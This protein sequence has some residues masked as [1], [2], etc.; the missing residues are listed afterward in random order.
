MPIDRARR[1]E[2]FIHVPDLS[3]VPE[4]VPSNSTR[5]AYFNLG[6]ARSVLVIP[7]RKDGTVLGTI[8]TYRQEVQPFT[9]KQITLLENFAA[10]A[11]I[12]MENARLLTETQQALD[13]QT[14]TTEVLQVINASPGDLAPV[15][16]AILEKA[17]ALCEAP[18]GSLVLYGGEQL[19][20]IAT[21]GYPSE[22]DDL[23]RRGFPPPLPFRR[24][25]DGKP[26]FLS[27]PAD[28]EPD[29]DDA[30]DAMR[31]AAVEI[32]GIRTALFVP[33]R[34][35]N[36]VLGYISA[37]RQEV[38]PFTYKQIALLQNFAGQAVIA[39]ENARLLGELRQ[40]TADLQQ[41]L[42]YQTA[43]SDVL[44]VISR[45]TFDLQPVLDTLVETATRLCV[46][47]Q[48]VVFDDSLMLVANFGYPA[49]YEAFHRA[50]GPT[51]VALSATSPTT[52][53]RAVRE[54][55][56]IHIEDV[57][58]VTGYSEAAITLGKQRTSLGVPLLREGEPIG[59]LALARQ[60]V[61]PFTERQIEL[62]RTFADQAVIAMENVRL[63][64]ELRQRTEEV[65]ELNRDL[66]ARVESAAL[67]CPRQA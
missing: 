11:V 15:F 1:G 24:L 16:D 26:Y 36:T 58:T 37:Q 59:V 67:V 42:E 34:K 14:A 46:A 65:G 2:R 44:Q 32:A 6:G 23:A 10:Q 49:E 4:F 18:L 53:A 7:L 38:R 9:D 66:E 33:L 56:V 25:L 27:K 43:T 5:R 30:D 51:P 48:A 35:D 55:R 17:H 61:E 31:H 63:L 29:R 52:T 50:R 28:Q 47:D 64:G 45:S 12:A 13:Q 62:V 21:R 60:R 39:M 40:R 41:S 19:R 22:Y 8:T 20:A 57:T 3:A 54:R